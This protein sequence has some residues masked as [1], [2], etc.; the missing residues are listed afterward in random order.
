MDL[1]RLEAWNGGLVFDYNYA[2][3]E[4]GICLELDTIKIMAQ[5]SFCGNCQLFIILLKA[6]YFTIAPPGSRAL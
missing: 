2:E 6:I 5:S 4:K 3:L 1:P